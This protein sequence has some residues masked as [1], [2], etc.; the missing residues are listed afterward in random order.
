MRNGKTS[1][2]CPNRVGVEYWYDSPYRYDGVSEWQCE[3][4]RFGRWCG[5]ELIGN[6]VEP[7]FCKGEIH[8]QVGEDTT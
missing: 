7:R 2:Q 3:H 5:Q 1:S 4:G 6:E 8:P